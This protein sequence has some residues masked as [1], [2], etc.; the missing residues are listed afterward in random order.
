VIEWLMGLLAG[1]DAW[2]LYG[3]TGFFA[4]LETSILVGVLVPGDTILL[5]AASTVT[6][7][8]RFVMLFGLTVV[9][10]LT[11]EA[12]GYLI[13]RTWGGRLRAS[14]LGRRLGEDR[15]AQAEQ[16]LAERG[17]KAVFAARFV[18][19]VHALVPVVAGTVRM[20]FARFIS[21]SAAG[22]VLWAALYVSTGALAGASWRSVS[23]QFG[24]ASY[25]LAAL[26]GVGIVGA[27]ALRRA[28]ARRPAGR[29]T[30]PQPVPAPAD[31]HP[32]CVPL[33]SNGAGQ[34]T[35]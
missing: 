19:F 4:L 10:S 7:P 33:V 11:G 29:S 26:V 20:P 22:A 12:V 6:T 32:S 9:G 25:M 5:L 15:W 34:S 27:W 3:A 13:G 21:Y 24:L 14:R 23:D 1:L 17:G 31:A 30:P 8:A 2:V 28:R 16:Y 18:A 35:D